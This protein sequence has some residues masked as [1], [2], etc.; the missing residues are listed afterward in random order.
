MKTILFLFLFLGLQ[1][2]GLA[3][4]CPFYQKYINKGNEILKGK[5]KTKFQDAINA[6]STAMLHCPAK[7]DEAQENIL[8]VFE[9]IIKLKENAEY[10]GRRALKAVIATNL[11]Q[12]E[13]NSTLICMEEA[14]T[15][16]K[17]TKDSLSLSDDAYNLHIKASEIINSDPTISL[18]IEEEAIKKY[19]KPYF[20]E[21][22]KKIYNENVFYKIINKQPSEITNIT[23]SP[24]G[25]S[26]LTGADNGIVSIITLKG[27]LIKEF[28]AHNN[29]I[30][31]VT[32]SSDGKKILTCSDDSTAKMWDLEGNRLQTF[33]GHTNIIYSVAFSPDDKTVLTGSEDK[34]AILWDLD[35]NILTKYNSHSGGLS[36]VAFSP[37]TH[38]DS[39]G[40]NMFATSSIDSTAILWNL[41]GDTLHT[42]RKH[43]GGIGLLAFS[44]KGNAVLTGGWDNKAMLWDLDGNVKNEFIGH[45]N[46]ISTVA[47][48]PDG[49]MF[50]TG[51]ADKTARLWNINGSLLKEFKGHSEIINSVAFAPDGQSI[52]TSSLD[53]TV[54]IWDIKGINLIEF[55][56]AS[57]ISFTPDSK[58]ILTCYDAFGDERS[59][60]KAILSDLKGKTLNEFI[61]KN[62]DIAYTAISPDGL[63]IIVGS[64]QN[65]IATLWNLEGDTLAKIIHEENIRSVAFSPLGKTI[66]S[67]TYSNAYLWDY[68]G[69]IVQELGNAFSAKFS[70]DGRKIFI[71]NDSTAYFWEH[72]GVSFKKIDKEIKMPKNTID[73][74]FSP[75]GKSIITCTGNNIASLIEL[76]SGKKMVDF[77]GHFLGVYSV[78]FSPNGKTVATVSDDKSVKLWDLNGNLIET[79]KGLSGIAM[80]VSFSPDGKF[81]LARFSTASYLWSIPKTLNEFYTNG[82]LE[83]LTEAQKIEFGILK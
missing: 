74:A 73:Y 39:I 71:Q 16:L 23:Y 21:T 18:R 62:S 76:S 46:Q 8:N 67:T 54:R 80:S 48:S 45:T 68:K 36:S 28:Q 14:Q 10:E 59:G 15:A 11:K 61:L 63:S 20:E 55:Q 41:E 32:F 2:E 31:L 7:S 77:K 40:R 51:S 12:L 35:G 47:F 6:Y 58:K 37:S 65:Q 82:N 79:F 43:K 3:Q 4:Y 30:E 50:L 60:S 22:A 70:P 5:T 29:R 57:T 42:F 38:E 64:L 52:V 69:K 9:E 66:L 44:P 81:I 26:I 33:K 27:E 78:A 25:K 1:L 19:F 17:K 24:D 13:L 75:D 83:P 72:N 34:S 49:N 53:S 56:S